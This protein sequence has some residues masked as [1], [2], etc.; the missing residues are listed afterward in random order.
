MSC[1]FFGIQLHASRIARRCRDIVIMLLQQSPAHHLDGLDHKGFQYTDIFIYMVN[2]YMVYIYHIN[3]V[4]II[5][6]LIIT[7]VGIGWPIDK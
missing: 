5:L 3:M 6:L 2:I 7:I 1:I 4:V